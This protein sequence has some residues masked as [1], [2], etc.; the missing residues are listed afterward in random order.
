MYLHI[1][2]C[3]QFV[4]TTICESV[5][6][7]SPKTYTIIHLSVW[8]L[9]KLVSSDWANIRCVCKHHSGPPQKHTDIGRPTPCTKEEPLH[10]TLATYDQKL[11]QIR[12]RMT[13]N[14]WKELQSHVVLPY[15]NFDTHA[16]IK[17]IIVYL[18]LFSPNGHGKKL[19]E[20]T[21]GTWSAQL[22]DSCHKESVRGL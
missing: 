20:P 6:I 4:S 8:N 11:R 22:P 14:D 18:S 21:A 2:I 17:S 13:S 5:E 10:V 15:L 9:W 16:M 1:H 19:G 3:K 7:Q 12:E